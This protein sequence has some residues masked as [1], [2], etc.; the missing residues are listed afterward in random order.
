MF[1]IEGQHGD[2]AKLSFIT[3]EKTSTSFYCGCRLVRAD[4]LCRPR[5]QSSASVIV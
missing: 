1:H 3:R 5:Q 2:L 4:A